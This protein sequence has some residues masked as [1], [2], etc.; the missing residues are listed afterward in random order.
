[1]CDC[2]ERLH[3][4]RRVYGPHWREERSGKSRTD[5]GQTKVVYLHCDVQRCAPL[6]VSGMYVKV[7]QKEE[8]SGKLRLA[9][10]S[11]VEKTPTAGSWCIY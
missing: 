8:Q 4:C 9:R 10:H 7:V 1:V 6:A 2:C 5:L 3:G 11:V